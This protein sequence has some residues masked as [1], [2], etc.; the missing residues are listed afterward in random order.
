MC[1]PLTNVFGSSHVCLAHCLGIF[2]VVEKVRSTRWLQICQ[3]K[4]EESDDYDRKVEPTAMFDSWDFTTSI[5]VLKEQY[6]RLRAD[7]DLSLYIIPLLLTAFQSRLDAPHQNYQTSKMISL[8]EIDDICTLDPYV[9]TLKCSK[10]V[11][12]IAERVAVSCFQRRSVHQN[13]AAKLKQTRTSGDEGD[14][15]DGHA[16]NASSVESAEH[17]VNDINELLH[18]NDS[19][20]TDDDNDN[21]D[22]ETATAKSLFEQ[23]LGDLAEEAEQVGVQAGGWRDRLTTTTTTNIHLQTEQ[24]DLDQ[25]LLDT[26]VDGGGSGHQPQSSSNTPSRWTEEQ[27]NIADIEMKQ[28]KRAV[29]SKKL[30]LTK[31]NLSDSLILQQVFLYFYFRNLA[32]QQ[33][34][35]TCYHFTLSGQLRYRCVANN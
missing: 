15:D 25:E 16:S 9:L 33:G 4:M 3:C 17:D 5:S 20:D 10:R 29:V 23:G 13:K 28:V 26:T 8:D 12:T 34:I 2:F 14:G 30:D 1:K 35:T 31:S 19:T 11:T 21:D 27:S 24:D 32:F 6:I 18:A 7:K 22:P